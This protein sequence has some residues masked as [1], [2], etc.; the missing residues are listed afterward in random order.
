MK[1]LSVWRW[2]P[3]ALALSLLLFPGP[4][5]FGEEVIVPTC[6]QDGY[7][8]MRHPDGTV[9][10]LRNRPA[11]GHSFGPWTFDGRG[12]GVH[13]CQVCGTV[14]T[15]DVSAGGLPRLFLDG[16]EAENGVRG[17]VLTG[18]AGD[19]SC[20]AR[21][22]PD[23]ENDARPAGVLELGLF[24]DSEGKTPLEHTFPGWLTNSRYT[25]TAHPEDPTSVRSLA[26]ALLWREAAACRASLP[27]RL[28]MLPLLGGTDGFT[29]TVWQDGVFGGLYTLSPRA[30]GS[31]FGMYRDEN[32]AVAV[33]AA[34]RA[35]E[36]GSWLPVWTGTGAGQPAGSRL[37]QLVT[38]VSESDDATFRNTLYRYLDV[39]GAVD[40]LLLT[41]AL[42]L[43]GNGA[44][45]LLYYGNQWIPVLCGTE[46]AFG[47]G[48]GPGVFRAASDGLPGQT[49]GGLSSGTGFL[50]YDRVLRVFGDRAAARWEELRQ[51][52]LTGDHILSV[53]DGLIGQIPPE[54]YALN[55][56]E[57]SGGL[58]PAQERARIA[59][60]L[61]ERLPLLDAAFGGY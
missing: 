19:F 50:L 26:V 13:T 37:S 30:D 59:A 7:V 51:S 11:P 42:G 57:G 34:D 32:T 27:E 40:A 45:V 39:D 16:A 23:W 15:V 17:A 46:N 53:V 9:T 21:V 1:R 48:P 54:A 10:A 52:L 61:E 49:D 4:W 8:L 47:A 2:F 60:Y 33:S 5:A 3:A 20:F 58:S 56:Q 55:G 29:V 24:A 38:Y 18:S 44:P 22:S 25:L 14:E 31:L 41:S 28:K 12:T 43:A 36:G 35:K 6:T